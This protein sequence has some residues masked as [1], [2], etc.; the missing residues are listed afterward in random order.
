MGLGGLEWSKMVRGTRTIILVPL[1][2]H[3]D[4]SRPRSTPFWVSQAKLLG[5]FGAWGETFHQNRP[6][7]LEPDLEKM[8]V[9]PR[10][11]VQ[12]PGLKIFRS[13]SCV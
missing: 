3:I 2:P 7:D 8:K 11:S 12:D 9:A 5:A 13:L 1:I 4:H 10:N 6:W